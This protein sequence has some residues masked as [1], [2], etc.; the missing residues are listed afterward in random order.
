MITDERRHTMTVTVELEQLKAAHR[1]TWAS[2]DYAAV[3]DAFVLPVGE[4]AVAN[5]GLRPGTEVLDV[6]AGSGNAAIPAALAGAR[7]TAL[8]LVP[9]LLA[10]GAERARRAGVDV[11]WVEGDAEA[12]PFPDERFDTVLSVVGV[13]F[14]PRHEVTAREIGRVTRPGGTIVLA[15]WTPSGFIGRMFT[16]MRPHLP[17]PPVGASPPPLWGRAEHVRDLFSGTGVELAFETH[18][19]SFHAESARAFIAYMADNY[20]P[21]L[22]ARERLAKEGRWTD[23]QRDLVAL[24][25]RSNVAE[26]GFRAPSEY[27]LTLG[28][29]RG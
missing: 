18:S 17:K 7:V 21:M 27:L 4:T 28:R 1:A 29:R 23:L 26:H 15:N 12:L 22:K 24:C 8:D 16:T 9:E 2:G 3:A 19:A 10:T 13:Q 20:G 11:D 5:A 6:A 25:E 14:A